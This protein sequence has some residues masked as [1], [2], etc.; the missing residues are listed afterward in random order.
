MSRQRRSDKRRQPHDTECDGVTV[1]PDCGDVLHQLRTR[2]TG[3]SIALAFLLIGLMTLGDYGFTIDEGASYWSGLR[4]LTLIS[5]PLHGERLEGWPKQE[6]PGYYF[7]LDSLRAA[8]ATL[9]GPIYDSELRFR[10]PFT[11][12]AE[13][14]FVGKRSDLAAWGLTDLFSAIHLPNLTASSL[15]LYFL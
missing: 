12:L 7:V 6:L 4:N 1:K 15:A 9:V 11:P 10:V 14:S 2:V 13:G 3:I 5:N 8:L